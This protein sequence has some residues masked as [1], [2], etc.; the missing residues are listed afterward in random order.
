MLKE[1]RL[2]GNVNDDGNTILRACNY[3]IPSMIASQILPIAN[4]QYS[5]NDKQEWRIQ[6]MGSS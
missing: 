4:S 5:E 1:L 2:F 3:L 6:S